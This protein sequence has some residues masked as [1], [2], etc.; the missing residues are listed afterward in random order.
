MIDLDATL[1]TA[2]SEKD[3]AKGN[4]KGGFGHHPA[5]GG[6]REYADVVEVTGMLDLSRS[7][8][9]YPGMRVIGRREHPHPVRP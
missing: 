5:D 6:L 8:K 2:H 3:D 9:T 1:V 4:V 7:T